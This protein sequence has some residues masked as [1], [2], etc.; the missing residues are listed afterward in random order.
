MVYMV[1]WTGAWQ[2]VLRGTG[3]VVATLHEH[4]TAMQVAALFNCGLAPHQIADLISCPAP[5]ER[6]MERP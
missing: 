2:V 5:L 1:K 6:F 4:V 3:E